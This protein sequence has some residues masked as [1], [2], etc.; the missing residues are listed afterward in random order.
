MPRDRWR[1]T[2]RLA[3][4][5]ARGYR[6]A[7]VR[8]IVYPCIPD[9]D[10]ED[11]RGQASS[12]L[13]IPLIKGLREI[14]V[15]VWNSNTFTADDLI[16]STSSPSFVLCKRGQVHHALPKC[17][18]KFCSISHLISS[19]IYCLQIPTR[20]HGVTSIC[21]I[22]EQHKPPAYCAPSAPPC[23][24]PP[25]AV[26]AP[27]APPYASPYT[28]GA[29]PGAAPYASYPPPA[30][31]PYQT[32]VYPPPPPQQFYAPQSSPPLLLLLLPIRRSPPYILSTNAR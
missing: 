22:D 10:G 19:K 32:C 12:S 2:I 23:M 1:K 26:T 25:P 20:E 8:E 29:Y 31:A 18:S 28:A 17:I 6:F 24:P 9:L 11:E 21:C 14:S 4:G 16:G 3:T 30:P 5:E 27:Y 15:A 7:G 13:V